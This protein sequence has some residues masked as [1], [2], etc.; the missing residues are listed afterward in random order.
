MA[1]ALFQKVGDVFAAVR[2]EGQGVLEGAINL[3]EI[4]L[5]KNAFPTY[6][7]AR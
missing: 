7:S 1:L 5:D 3:I 2:I 6:L 4:L